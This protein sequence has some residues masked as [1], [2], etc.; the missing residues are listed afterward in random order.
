MTSSSLYPRT[1]SSTFCVGKMSFFEWFNIKE[2]MNT[3]QE[4]HAF[5]EGFCETFCFWRANYEPSKELLKHLKSE[6]HYYVFGRVVG[7]ISVVG[8]ALLVVKILRKKE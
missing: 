1:G 8:L 7:F 2:F 6:H 4:W 5:V 3:Y